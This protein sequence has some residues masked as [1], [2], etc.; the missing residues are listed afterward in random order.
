MPASRS[1]IAEPRVTALVMTI[2]AVA[3]VA[4][5]MAVGVALGR[6]RGPVVD[7]V[8]PDVGEAISADQAR[9]ALDDLGARVCRYRLD[10]HVITSCNAH[11]AAGFGLA[12]DALVGRRLDE[13]LSATELDA[14][15]AR[16]PVLVERGSGAPS[17]NLRTAA[18]GSEH[19]D[20]WIDRIVVG[21]DGAPEVLA[22]GHDITDQAMAER[23][24]RSSEL[25]YRTLLEELPVPIVVADLSGILVANQSAAD[26]V[27]LRDP[28]ELVG[29]A[30]S[31]FYVSADRV[32][33]RSRLAEVDAGT[34]S[35]QVMRGEIETPNGRR[36][37]DARVIDVELDGRP[38]ALAVLTDVTDHLAALDAAASSEARY[39]NLLEQLPLPAYVRDRDG[40]ILL[41][42]PAALAWLGVRADDLIGTSIVDRIAPS[43]HALA[44]DVVESHALLASFEMGFVAA[45]GQERRAETIA[46]PVELDGVEAVFVVL[47]DVTDHRHAEAVLLAAE[48]RQRMVLDAADTAVLLHDATG[49]ITFAN[50][51]A[52]QL[53]G[54]PEP[55]MLEGL[56]TDTWL[57][58]A[59][60][61]HGEPLGRNAALVSRVVDG[62]ETVSGLELGLTVGDGAVR[63]LRASATAAEG[64]EGGDAGFVAA[65][66]SFTDVTV[67]HEARVALAD[68]E[69]R[70]RA[71]AEH[72]PVAIFTASADARLDYV[73]PAWTALTGRTAADALGATAHEQLPGADGVDPVGSWRRL[74]DAS[75][76]IEHDLVRA[77]DAVLHVQTTVARVRGSDGVDRHVGTMVDL[78]ERHRMQARLA[79]EATHDG[80]TG[81][82]N[83]TLLVERLH[84]VIERRG[85]ADH[86]AV[87]FIDLDRFK[88]VNDLYGH[89]AGD[90]LL[91]AVAGRLMART[92]PDD[93]LAR[94]GGDEFVLLAAELPS[95]S[96]A[97]ALAGR[98]E[99][100][101]RAP[102]RLAK[103]TVEIG[104]S[105]GVAHIEAPATV[106]ALLAEADAQMYRAK[107]DHHHDDDAAPVRVMVWSDDLELGVPAMDDDHRRLVAS[108]AAVGT[109][110][111][112]S[113]AAAID[114]AFDALSAETVA[115]FAR[116]EAVMVRLGYPEVDAHREEHRR[117][118]GAVARFRA[119]DHGRADGRSVVRLLEE[120]F[121][122]HV[123]GADQAFATWASATVDTEHDSS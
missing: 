11:Y 29:R 72:A 46:A 111:G 17:Q 23:A 89:D 12:P 77:D 90:E 107:Q 7:P 102:F 50:V 96:A 8:A 85:T 2:V 115:H 81:L 4:G 34:S 88:A 53:L 74:G 39:R 120:W 52:A 66:C 6:R 15:R 64:S 119:Q 108:I 116:E 22:V 61:V 10:D 20:V 3:L 103:A 83:R 19:V 45:G 25:R 24:L 33:V 41:A 40:T 100:E 92:R 28:A 91:R 21:S 16:L 60:D 31:D 82:A 26:L 86:P 37:V 59:I 43:D 97:E 113:D 105:I 104:A 73:N 32:G 112:A 78:T 109:S 14:L 76:S 55:D 63:W 49:R 30:P 99:A 79:H 27:G 48:R 56:H 36:A 62:G 121:T 35:S 87:L 123:H 101:L 65:V 18:D 51:A 67:Q 94:I 54:E 117:L 13:V 80:L 71:L 70:F 84:D 118:L 44:V 98:L 9:T 58:D 69:A 42:N 75:W 122:N 57:S 93:T 95:R 5:S 38:V 114:A 68:S 110:L 1:T 47:R 106:D